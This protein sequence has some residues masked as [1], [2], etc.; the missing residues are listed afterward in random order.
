MT[1][2]KNYNNTIDTLKQLGANHYQIKTVTTGDIW[3]IDLE[4]NTLFPLMHVNPINAVAAT[5]QMTLNFQIFIMDLVFND[6]SNEQEVLSD[7]LSICNDLIGTLK[8]GESLY[9]SNVDQGENAAYF[10]E[11]DVTIEPFTERF[12]NSV[13]GWVFTLPIVIENN[14]NTCIAPQAT[15]YA[16]K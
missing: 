10:T 4:K 2:F 16:G 14:Y 7:C 8:N 6:E 3:E 15:T 1:H 9:L 12:D 5:H 11:G 13:T